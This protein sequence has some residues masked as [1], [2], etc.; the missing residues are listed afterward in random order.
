MLLKTQSIINEEKQL[1]ASASLNQ[2]IDASGQLRQILLKSTWRL[3]NSTILQ[4]AVKTLAE[5]YCAFSIPESQK[6]NPAM[7]WSL[8]D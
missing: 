7:L 4:A 6:K 1:Y 8:T 2:S 5:F 3:I